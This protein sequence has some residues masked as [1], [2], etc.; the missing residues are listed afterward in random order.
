M[1]NIGEIA[2]AMRRYTVAV[3]LPNGG[4]SG[5]VWDA[6]AGCIITN[7]H[8]ARQDKVEVE[9]WDGRRAPASVVKRDQ[10]RDLA[11][12]RTSSITAPS[13]TSADSSAIR[14]GEMVL[15][16]GNP[17][18]FIGAL[19][20]GVVHRRGPVAQLGNQ[21]WIQAAIH[22]APGNS[23][24]PL[25]DA[26]GRLVGVNTMVLGMG[27]QAQGLGLATPS[28]AVQQFLA[29]RKATRQLGVSVHPT[30]FRLGTRT[31]MGLEIVDITPGSL[32]EAASLKKRDVLLGADGR[33]FQSAEDL[34]ERIERGG[35]LQLQFLR[36]GRPLPREVAI[37]LGPEQSQAA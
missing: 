18:G 22:L 23:G 10:R 30:A 14:P 7:A 3:R 1:S 35:L 27:R 6:A 33:W 20:T 34:V 16:V 26:Q 29:Q 11:E 9:F 5:I 37:A 15:A 19:T 17:L 28:N 4:G 13:A 32:A 25:A 8:V 36:D 24:G 2:E 31:A 21:E 12:L